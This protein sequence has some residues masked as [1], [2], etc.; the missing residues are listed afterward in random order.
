M[1]KSSLKFHLNVASLVGWGMAVSY[2]NLERACCE[3]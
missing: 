1:S 2:E 3:A